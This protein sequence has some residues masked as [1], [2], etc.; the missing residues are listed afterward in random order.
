MG[1]DPLDA[2]GLSPRQGPNARQRRP[3]GAAYHIF[4]R[5]GSEVSVTWSLPNVRV[6]DEAIR[7]LH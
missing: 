5:R 2:A 3:P 7:R 1:Q 4:H 6:P